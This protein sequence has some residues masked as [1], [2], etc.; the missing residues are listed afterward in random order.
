ME[1]QL[2]NYHLPEE[3]IAQVPLNERAASR[4]LYAN[5][6]AKHLEDFQFAQ[7]PELL[8][9]EFEK[10]PLIVLNRTRVFRARVRVKRKSGGRG[11][12]FLLAKSADDGKFP[13]LIRPQKKL[14]KGDILFADSFD[15]DLFDPLFQIESLSPPQV[16]LLKSSLENVL[17]E[18]GEMPL[19]PYIVRDPARVNNQFANLDQERYQTCYAQEEGSVA[20]TTAGLHFTPAVIEQC[21]KNGCEFASVLLHVGLGTFMPVQT[22]TIQ[23]HLMHEENYSVPASTAQAIA[24]AIIG[25]RPIIFVGTTSLRTVE[26]YIRKVFSASQVSSGDLQ[27]RINE[28]VNSKKFSEAFE[29]LSDKWFATK[30]FIH[31]TNLT[32]ANV[33]AVGDAII[34]N[35]HQPQSTLVMLVAALLGYPFWKK[36]YDHAIASNYRFLSYGDSSFLRFYKGDL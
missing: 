25:K 33:P 22:E 9:R 30:L 16:S 1:T 5:P 12:V 7:L 27:E 32:Q 34:T 21:E 35:F 11:E 10:P 14:R 26:S 6:S 3:L 36:T 19:P 20:A 23:E 2:F 13:C 28:A 31:P 18:F 24:R 4:L 8:K 15:S 29:S 17:N